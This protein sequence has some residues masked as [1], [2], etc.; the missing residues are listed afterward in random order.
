MYNRRATLCRHTVLLV[1]AIVLG[2]L[3]LALVPITGVSAAV[4]PLGP[5]RHP[6]DL[7]SQE[8]RL[9]PNP[10]FWEAARDR[11]RRLVADPALSASSVAFETVAAITCGHQQ[12]LPLTHW[13]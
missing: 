1:A 13:E 11:R 10:P 12:A 2:A 4:G 8:R 7:R 9:T 6:D 3:L 5:C